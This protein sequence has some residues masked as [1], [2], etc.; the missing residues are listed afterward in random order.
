MPS[1]LSV[2][3]VKSGAITDGNCVIEGQSDYEEAQQLATFIRVGAINL[4]LEEMESNVVGAQLGGKALSSSVKAAIIGLILVMLYMIICYGLC[5]AVASVGLAIY[6]TLVVAFIYLF[7]I[8][9]TLPGIAGV[10]LG[11]GMAVDANVIIISRI[12]EEIANG[13]SVLTSIKEGYK[14][15]LSA[16]IE[17][18]R[19]SCR[20]R[21]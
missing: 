17:I 15:A 12:R 21:V 1:D 11:I 3:T 16:I 19:A 18:G 14:K 7:E 13:R 2:P 10:I 6:T 5:G 9:L 8:T 20:E 4:K